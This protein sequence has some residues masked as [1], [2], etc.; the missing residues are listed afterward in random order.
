MVDSHSE[1]LDVRFPPAGPYFLYYRLLL[2]DVF[3]L[4]LYYFDCQFELKHCSY[5]CFR[6]FLVSRLCGTCILLRMAYFLV[7]TAAAM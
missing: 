3:G 5:L 6:S 7:F 2:W 1:A 4:V